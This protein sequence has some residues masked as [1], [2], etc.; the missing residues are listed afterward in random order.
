MQVPGNKGKI[1][2]HI[3]LDFVKTSYLLLCTK[4]YILSRSATLYLKTGCKM[5][6]H[7]ILECVFQIHIVSKIC[8]LFNE[9]AA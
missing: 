2:L 9:H 7:F 6:G 3:I 5:D 4:Q 1:L 8:I